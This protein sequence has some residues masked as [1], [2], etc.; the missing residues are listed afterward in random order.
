MSNTSKP[1]KL[2]LRAYQVGFGDC[3]LLTFHYEQTTARHILIDFGTKRKPKGY[4]G[5]V[6]LK[7]AEDIKEVCGGRL[8]AV[9]ATHRHQDHISGFTTKPNGKGSGDIIKSCK[10]GAVIQ[11]WTEHPDAHDPAL[12]AP[13]VSAHS[14]A[15]VKSLNSMQMVADAAISELDRKDFRLMAA[16]RLRTVADNN[17]KNPVAVDNLYNMTKRRYYVSY[18]SRSG[19]EKVLPGVK[20]HVLG[21]PTLKDRPEIVREG[22]VA[23]EFWALQAGAGRFAAHPRSLFRGAKRYTDF[24]P[25]TNWFVAHLRAVRG[26]QLKGIIH[27]VDGALN[28]TSLILLFEVGKYKLLFP[29]DAEIENWSYALEQ[30]DV[31]QLLKGVNLYKVGHHGSTNATPRK[32][33]WENFSNKGT[34]K[35]LK[36]VISTME[37]VYPGKR[38]G[39]EVP[40]SK[41][42][43]EL[44]ANS[45]YYSTEGVQS[46]EL[47]E[48]IDIDF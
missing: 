15:L 3:F 38:E 25:H 31:K 29:G 22:E 14:M 17:T 13:R 5:D 11:P 2:T 21:P 42:V 33:L 19:L 36:T 9:V 26:N 24:P 32:S 44:K 48:K 4:K 45:E 35:K 40:R 39:R 1:S 7:I 23:E 30:P 18:G 46:P 27:A 41:L 34:S 8:D 28:N 47:C 10:V 6:M 43:R 20:V 12:K 16:A 37:G